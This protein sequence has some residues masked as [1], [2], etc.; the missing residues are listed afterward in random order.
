MNH[1]SVNPTKWSNTLKQ[2]VGKFPTNCL[3]VFDHFVGSALKG[4]SK[5]IR[6]WLYDYDLLGTS[7]SA[8]KFYE[9]I[10]EVHLETPFTKTSTVQ[11]TPAFTS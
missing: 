8:I 9:V 6:E 11:L 5:K 2:F 1:L 10:S 3:R 4:L 7:L